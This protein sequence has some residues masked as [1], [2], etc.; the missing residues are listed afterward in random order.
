MF[1]TCLVTGVLLGAYI[2][3]YFVCVSE[4]QFGFTPR[5]DKVYSAP[6][7]P[8]PTYL[9]A[10]ALNL[11]RPIHL[12]DRTCLRRSKWTTQPAREGELT[13][14]GPRRLLFS[15]PYTNSP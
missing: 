1:T 13:V 8:V 14:T 2:V 4:A 15:V 11:Y 5:G 10:A 3:S 12:L 6:V 7:Y 9:G